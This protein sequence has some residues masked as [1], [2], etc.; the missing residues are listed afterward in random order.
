MGQYILCGRLAKHPFLVEELG[1]HL[2]S[3]EELCYYIFHN[4]S[5]IHE[6][7]VDDKL[8]RFLREE[9]LMAELADRLNNWKQKQICLTDKLLLILHSIEYYSKEEIADFEAEL[10]KFQTKNPMERRMDQADLLAKRKKY[11]GA[12]KIYRSIIEQ[13][14]DYNLTSQFYASVLEH[15]A[16]AY[17]HLLLYAEAM[18][19]LV[20][21][22]HECKAENLKKQIY[23]LSLL[24]GHTLPADVAGDR[25]EMEASWKAKYENVQL[26]TDKALESGKVATFYSK[27][28]SG[29]NKEYTYIENEKNNY[30]EMALSS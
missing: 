21:A 29:N 28:W 3:A 23:Y 25:E 5:M 9:L 20:A 19:C 1:V 13:P 10:V 15:M 24:S 6:D 8:I 4:L 30:R 2:Y 16:N 22:F 14:R 17:L 7:F 26:E 12:L 18:E 11:L 27:G